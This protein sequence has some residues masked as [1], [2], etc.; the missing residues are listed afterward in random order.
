MTVRFPLL[1]WTILVSMSFEICL[2]A[3]IDAPLYPC[4]YGPR[5]HAF[6]RVCE[7]A[8]IKWKI[9]FRCGGSPAQLSN[10]SSPAGC[11]RCYA[12]LASELSGCLPMPPSST[13]ATVTPP[14]LL[15]HAHRHKSTHTHPL[16]LTDG[17]ARVCVCVCVLWLHKL[18]S[19]VW[20]KVCPLA[21]KVMA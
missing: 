13:P 14:H 16:R 21:I 10:D 7:C 4:T 17:P 6:V 15:A 18:Q 8:K 12:L 20:S 11:D 2:I 3:L 9:P 5:V 19:R 1:I